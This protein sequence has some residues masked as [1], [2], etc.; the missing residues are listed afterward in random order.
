MEGA[1]GIII[2]EEGVWLEGL[3][4]CVKRQQQENKSYDCSKQN[5]EA[6]SEKHLIS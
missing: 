3:W 1:G 5:Q 4:K 6:M 2:N